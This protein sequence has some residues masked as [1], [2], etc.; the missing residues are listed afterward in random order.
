M[1]IEIDTEDG[2][3]E[4]IAPSALGIAEQ[5]KQKSPWN[6]N[7][8]TKEWMIWS[9]KL[10]SNKPVSLPLGLT[11]ESAGTFLELMEGFGKLRITS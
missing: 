10:I 3:D 5:I 7:R 11:D 9:L 2:I 4:F 1:K 8:D 6:R